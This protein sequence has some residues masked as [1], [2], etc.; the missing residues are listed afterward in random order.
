MQRFP[1]NK[2]LLTN[3]VK[4][5]R[6]LSKMPFSIQKVFQNK[7]GVEWEARELFCAPNAFSEY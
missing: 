2:L 3:G 5:T 7:V 6:W 1:R 4:D